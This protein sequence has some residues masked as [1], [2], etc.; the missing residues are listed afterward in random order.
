[1]TKLNQII[2]VTAG[3]KTKTAETLT[4]TYK[5]VQKNEL[6]QG[7]NRTYRPLNDGDETKPA[8]NK[9]VQYNVND[10]VVDFSSAIG[11]LLDVVYTQD[12]ANCQ[13]KANIEV[14]GTVL[15]KDVPVTHLLFLEK[16]L[17]DIRTFVNHLPVLDPSEN[18]KFDS[19][20]NTWVTDVSKTN[21]T[22]KVYKNHEKAPATEKHP[23]QVEV[24]T[25]D[26]KV[27]EWDTVKFS[28]AIPVK[29]KK[30]TLK[31]VEKLLDA[32]KS[33][34]EAANSMDVTHEKISS[35]ILDF[36]FKK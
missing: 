36:V 28:G 20:K 9:L 17:T 7:I 30:D 16:Q 32:I 21:A 11:E 24:Y 13:A 15:A 22:K 25:E 1:M 31:R 26:I 18:W 5:K 14:D 19:N 10:A 33:A 29:Q 6:F 2:A 12:K 35:N 34:R 4:E 27:G 3:K 23:A 8:E